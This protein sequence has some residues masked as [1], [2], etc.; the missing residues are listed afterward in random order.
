MRE[1][2]KKGGIVISCGSADFNE[3][4]TKSFDEIFEAADMKMYECKRLLKAL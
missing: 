2:Q 3:K 4:T 1:N